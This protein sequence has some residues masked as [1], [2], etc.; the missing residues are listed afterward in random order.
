MEINLS[1]L[2]IKRSAWL[3]LKEIIALYWPSLWI[4][5]GMRDLLTQTLPSESQEAE[6]LSP[7]LKKLS[8][9]PAKISQGN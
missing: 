7:E 1:C 3:I 2:Q 8:Y 6:K 5:L 9:T 4:I